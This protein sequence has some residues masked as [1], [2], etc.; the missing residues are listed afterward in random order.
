M[1]ARRWGRRARWAVLAALG[2]LSCR[3][4]AVAVDPPREGRRL[5]WGEQRELERVAESTFHEV[6][7]VVAGLA[8]HIRL[9][10]RWGTDVIAE[11]GENGAAAQPDIVA[12]TL[13]PERDVRTTIRAHLRATLAHELHHLARSR[14]VEPRTLVD[15]VVHEGLATAFERDFAGV[16]PP[17]GHA[18]P[19]GEALAWTDELLHQPPGADPTPWMIRHSDGRRWVGMRVG[20]LLVDR[21]RKASGRTAAQLVAAPTG[22]VLRLAGVVAL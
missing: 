20:T 4:P 6:R 10:V 17:W 21:A 16:D 9:V 1:I 7:T 14:T 15:R 13:D 5:S 22:E 18:P 19:E 8:A 12:W 11:T 3:S 2:A